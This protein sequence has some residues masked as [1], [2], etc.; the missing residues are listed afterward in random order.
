MILLD[1][2]AIIHSLTGNRRAAALDRFA[3]SLRV[4]PISILEL[5]VLT[6][7]GRLRW[8]RG[9]SVSTVQGASRWLVDDPS[10]A[11]L[12][13][14][15]AV[16]GWTTEPF[17]RLLVAHARMRRWKLATSDGLILEHLSASEVVEL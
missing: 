17:D 5:Q 13:E 12:V 8:P 10:L 15:A 9:T 11:T 6:E 2:S 14:H 7:R 1:T 16:L 3:G 4:S